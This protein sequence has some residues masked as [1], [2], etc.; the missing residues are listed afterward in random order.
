MQGPAFWCRTRMCCILFASRGMSIHMSW[1]CYECASKS[2]VEENKLL[3]KVIFVFFA[4]K[5]IL[6]PWENY[7]WTTDVAW[8]ILMMSLLPFWALNV[9]VTLLSIQGQKALGFHKKYLNLCY[10]DEWRYYGSGL[11][12][13][14]WS[15]TVRQSSNQLQTTPAWKFLV[16]LKTLIS[17]IRCVWLGLEL[18]C[19]E[20]TNG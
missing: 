3:N 2:D 1:Y 9:S 11:K 15:A 16:I 10:K 14:S 17:W 19:A 5:S 7:A 13:N 20:L 8:T 18:K 4:Q 6:I 12:L